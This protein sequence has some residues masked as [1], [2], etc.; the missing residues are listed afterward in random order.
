MNC[1]IFNNKKILGFTHWPIT[2]LWQCKSI[3]QIWLFLFFI[4]HILSHGFISGTDRPPTNWVHCFIF[5]STVKY[6]FL[7]FFF[8][9][10]LFPVVSPPSFA[11][12]VCFFCRDFSF[13]TQW[14]PQQWRE[15]TPSPSW[16]SCSPVFT[17]SVLF[18]RPSRFRPAS[19]SSDQ[20]PDGLM[21]QVF[22]GRLTWTA[23]GVWD[24]VW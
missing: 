19:G 17:A 23:V 6:K 3:S 13:L 11:L 4:N 10:I 1:W 7:V 24:P 18:Y 16:L 14:Q 12:T 2:A 21:T 9:K 22:H 5:K 20:K 8:H 15:F